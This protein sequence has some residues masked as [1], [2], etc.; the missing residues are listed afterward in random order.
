MVSEERARWARALSVENLSPGVPP[1]WAVS[2]H[3]AEPR[4][5][6]PH[7][8][9]SV[10]SGSFAKR[11]ANFPEADSKSLYVRCLTRFTATRHLCLVAL[12]LFA[13]LVFSRYSQD[14]RYDLVSQCT[15]IR[16][17]SFAL[18]DLQTG[19]SGKFDRNDCGRVLTD[20]ITGKFGSFLLESSW[21]VPCH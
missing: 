1:E 17:V 10:I 19:G 20:I 16:A 21:R 18:F 12:N 2:C 8:K 4:Q 5:S 3:L 11:S 14:R 15:H 7:V 6:L 9:S 13:W